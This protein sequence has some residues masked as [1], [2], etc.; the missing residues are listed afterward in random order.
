MA[1][2][3]AMV[4]PKIAEVREVIEE[5]K[6]TKTF[7]LFIGGADASEFRPGRFLMI[8]AKGFGEIPISLSDLAYGSDGGVIATITV[9]GVGV[10]S[11]YMLSS[12]KAGSMIGARGPFGR[13]WP[14]E[15]ARGRD[16]LIAA[17]GIGFA[18]LRPILK[19]VWK[20]REDYG[21]VFVVY[22]AR[23]PGD[24]LYR[25]ELDSYRSLPN[26]EIRFTIDRPAEGWMGEVGLVPDV[27]SRI[28]LGSSVVSFI[29]GPEIM[30]KIASRR[31]VEM[32]LDP[33]SIYVSLERRMRCGMGI[34][35]TCQFGH[36][37][38][39]RDGP[40]FSYEEVSRYMEVEGI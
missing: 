5:T 19:H 34:C 24:M 17:G 22:G 32:G 29:C 39:C 1:A 4:I 6:D 27:L 8:Y 31:L 28:K 18:P 38:V 3:E 14:L 21:R 10:V 9:R 36:Y 2:N 12:L 20:N 35:G 23:S 37:Y 40:V 30:M 33:R 25:Y 7:K 15:E 16:L 13:G 26:A 11:R